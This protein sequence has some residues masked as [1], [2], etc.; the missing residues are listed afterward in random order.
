[1]LKAA[2]STYIIATAVANSAKAK[3]YDED[4]PDLENVRLIVLRA[5]FH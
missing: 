5:R 2:V 1:M 4:L 3:F